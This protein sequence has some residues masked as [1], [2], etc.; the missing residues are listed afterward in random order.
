MFHIIE[1]APVEHVIARAAAT[2]YEAV[3]TWNE[4]ERAAA[5]IAVVAWLRAYAA[6]HKL[7]AQPQKE[8]ARQAALWAALAAR[9]SGAAVDAKQFQQWT[10][11]AREILVSLY[12][13]YDDFVTED[14]GNSYYWYLIG[15]GAL[16]CRPRNQGYLFH[17]AAAE[18]LRLLLDDGYL[19]WRKPQRGYAGLIT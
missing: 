5:T 14:C 10:S 15:Q 11:A 1:K 19:D 2:L 7:H 13:I 9:E 6:H 8:K 12:E 3:R 18:M 4:E 16:G 17:N